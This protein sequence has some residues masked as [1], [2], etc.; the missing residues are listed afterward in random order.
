MGHHRAV[1]PG[2]RAAPPPGRRRAEVRPRYGRLAVLGASVSVTAIAV[3]GSIGVLPSVAQGDPGGSAPSSTPVATDSV[4]DSVLAAAEASVT[5]APQPEAAAASVPSPS[6]SGQPAA[7]SGQPQGPPPVPEDSGDGRR[8]VFDQSDQRVWL[9]DDDEDVARTYLVSGS[10]TDNLQPGTY[11][12]YSRSEDAVGV[13]DSGTMQWFV[14]FTQ[15]PSGAAIGF[16]DI[17]V[18]DGAPVQTLG[19]LGTPQSHGCIRQKEVDALALWDFAPIGTEV[20]VVA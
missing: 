9:I 6:P 13:D 19:Q 1:R 10:V 3:L 18:D 16:H 8:V 4:V 17:P 14:R 5:P 11:A 12:V 15:G 2:R 20:D 7:S